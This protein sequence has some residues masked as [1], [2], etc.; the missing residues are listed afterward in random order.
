MITL[1]A[2]VFEDDERDGAFCI[3]DARD[4]AE[5]LKVKYQEFWH[6]ALKLAQAT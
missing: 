1:A 5:N 3:Y 4:R 2:M 6:K